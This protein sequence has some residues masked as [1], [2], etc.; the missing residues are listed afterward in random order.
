M[1][2]E[3]KAGRGASMR[4]RNT[5]G[6]PALEPYSR[7]EWEMYFN[8]VAVS[9]AAKPHTARR[10]ARDMARLCPYADVAAAGLA[11]VNTAIEAHVDMTGPEDRAKWH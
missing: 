10:R 3:R 9:L 5:T 4:S 1:S 6:A 8:A 11:R 2:T 7:D